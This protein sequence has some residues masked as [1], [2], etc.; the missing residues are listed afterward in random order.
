MN[1]MQNSGSYMNSSKRFAL[2]LPVFWS[3]RETRESVENESA[4][5]KTAVTVTAFH[6][7]KSRPEI[8]TREH[9]SRFMQGASLRGQASILRRSRSRSMADYIDTRR[10]SW[11]VMFIARKNKLLLATCNSDADAKEEEARVGH[12][13]LSSIRL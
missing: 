7:T 13:L 12:K 4:S 5:G 11:R 8:D 6:R 1:K 10:A 3:L 9:L 2:R